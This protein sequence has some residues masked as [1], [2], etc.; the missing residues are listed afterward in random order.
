MKIRK[1]IMNQKLASLLVIVLVLGTILEYGPILSFAEEEGNNKIVTDLKA[2]RVED[3]VQLTWEYQPASVTTYPVDSYE[4]WL[5]KTGEEILL[6]QGAKLEELCSSTII[7]NARTTAETYTVKVYRNYSVPKPIIPAPEVPAPGSDVTGSDVSGG[8]VSGSDVSGGDASGSDA[9][10]GDMSEKDASGGNAGDLEKK[11]ELID[12]SSIVW[13]PQYKVEFH[14]GQGGNLTFGGN[15]Y[16]KG[17]EAVYITQQP[18]MEFQV[19]PDENYDME[20]FQASLPLESVGDN[21][22]SWEN[23]AADITIQVTFSK[24]V[25]QPVLV[26][27]THFSEEREN[28]SAIGENEQIAFQSEDED[29]T[30][31]YQ[32]L[33]GPDEAVREENWM[34]YVPET[35]VYVENNY[36]IGV[37]K[38]KAVLHLDGGGVKEGPTATWYYSTLPALPQN[39]VFQFTKIG[40][41]GSDSLNR[42]NWVKASDLMEIQIADME[43][44]TQS[45]ADTYQYILCF[46]NEDGTS[47]EKEFI[48]SQEAGAYLCSLGSELE[49]GRYEIG[50]TIKNAGGK[51]HE[52]QNTDY[53]LAYDNSIP[54][55][56]WTEKDGY[57][58][59]RTEDK[60]YFTRKGLQ[61]ELNAPDS[62]PSS[63]IS[64][65]SYKVGDNDWQDI[66]G[67]CIALPLEVLSDN[68][69]V[70]FR[71]KSNSGMTAETFLYVTKDII[72]PGGIDGSL[73]EELL[74]IEKEPA[75]SDK[76]PADSTSE[77]VNNDVENKIYYSPSELTDMVLTKEAEK[78]TDSQS[79]IF[80]KYKVQEFGT[81][82]TTGDAK[83]IASDA[84]GN[85]R[86]VLA[87]EDRLQIQ[88]KYNLYIWTEDEAGNPSAPIVRMLCYDNT[89]PVVSDAGYVSGLVE[90]NYLEQDGTVYKYFASGNVKASFRI[91]ET[92]AGLSRIEYYNIAGGEKE[93]LFCDE[94]IAGRKMD[95]TEVLEHF[96]NQPGKYKLLIKVYD[97]AGNSSETVVAEESFIL[98][99]TEPVLNVDS[100][101]TEGTWINRDAVFQIYAFD[102][103]SG[104]SRVEYTINGMKKTVPGNG[105]GSAL[106]LQAVVAEEAKDSSGFLLNIS[107]YSN[108]GAVK[109]Y[110]GRVLIDRTAPVISLSG[111]EVGKVYGN[112]ASLTVKIQEDIYEFAQAN[113]NI[114]R[115]LDGIN[116]PYEAGVFRFSDVESVNNF[117]FAADGEYSVIVSAKDAAGNTAA[118]QSVSFIVDSTAPVIH[119]SGIQEGHYYKESPTLNL[120]VIESFYESANIKVKVTRQLGG[121]TK[122]YELPGMDLYAKESRGGYTFQEEGTYTVEVSAKDAAGNIAEKQIV[123]FVVDKTV[124]ELSIEGFTNHL[125]TD[126]SVVVQFR[127]SDFY[128]QGMQVSAKIVRADLEGKDTE[129]YVAVGPITG[130]VTQVLKEITEDGKYTIYLEA[131]DQAGNASRVE[132]SF[133]IDTQAPDIRFVK[134]YDG[135]YF[136]S[137]QLAHSLED[138]IHDFTLSDYEITLNG[139]FYDGVSEVTEDG[140]Y[141]LE[142]TARDEVGHET[143]EKAEFIVDGTAPMIIFGGTEDKKVNY[144]PVTLSIS[145]KDEPDYFTQITIDGSTQMIQEG[146]Q[147]TLQFQNFGTY[148]VKVTAKDLAGNVQTSQITVIYAKETIFL[149][150]YSNKPLFYSTVTG[151]AVVIIAAGI[152]MIVVKDKKNRGK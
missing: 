2:E 146:S 102:P 75:L 30:I 40:S 15:V 56:Q 131:L 95:G 106:S 96:I 44:D 92:N 23:I 19:Q 76:N 91:L 6:G 77:T 86:L 12:S 114:Q 139:M 115:R 28:P 148:E 31:Y 116:M 130:N 72:P 52:V 66:A 16:S 43:Q 109:N 22:Y 55:I 88:G 3:S 122:E 69:K 120:Q 140:K 20:Q 63:G 26:E 123:S 112:Q 61:F 81:N 149:K 33:N 54:Q 121:E 47:V 70:C 110:N 68:T 89:K 58:V 34:A 83:T 45:T 151:M 49:N 21:C 57:L 97:M 42:D 94:G 78:E 11:R 7:E 119:L 99:H 104:I 73:E 38:A 62:V 143:K 93:L 90:G 128:Y 79:D 48:W 129:S 46:R 147:Q 117:S 82:F 50:Y 127:I 18:G 145:L 133:I 4:V 27:S 85:Y 65:Y 135:K 134:E 71:V 152:Y 126:K 59:P 100:N 84:D 105:D 113:I 60:H 37:V 32:F 10:G 138:M 17:S 14:I 98:D 74:T 64:G 25:K 101:G 144:E 124:P 39:L 137:F 103:E 142:V 53:V 29:I 111:I 8:D 80:V 13:N 125:I 108:A 51:Q 87:D 36:H 136:Q 132:K 107:A 118:A 141:L 41:D 150:W 1:E 24:Q 35:D 5:Q 67:N 9:S